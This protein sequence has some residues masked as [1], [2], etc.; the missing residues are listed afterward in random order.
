M[1]IKPKKSLGQHFLKDRQITEKIAA[2]LDAKE[3]DLVI[4]VGPG[5]GALTRELHKRFRNLEVFEVDRR[6]I[7]LLKSEFPD[8]VIHAKSILDADF[9]SL[10]KERGRPAIVGN[11]PYFLTSPIL[12]RVMDQ[13]D[14]FSQAVFMIQKEVADRLIA[15]TRS[16]EYGILSVQAQVLGSVE[17]LFTVPPE[18]FRP[19]PKVQSAVIRYRP[20]NDRY[21]RSAR[22][23][24]VALD[25]F[26]TVVRTAF[27]QRRKML[28]NAL[29]PLFGMEFPPD[30]DT[31]RRAEELEPHEFVT[32]ASWYAQNNST[33]G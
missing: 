14:L 6:A 1:D 17:L 27:Q 28:S 7:T 5:M 19:P 20:G 25:V 11:L 26:K 33:K 31:G 2:S 10:A 12:F 13:G 32:L 24:P 16:K 15:G 18:A 3:N 30:F 8:M 4:E 21:K 22:D 9:V 23:M 29:K